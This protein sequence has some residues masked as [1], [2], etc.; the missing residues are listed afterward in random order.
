[1]RGLANRLVRAPAWKLWVAP[2]ASIGFSALWLA[3]SVRRG[4]IGWSIV[5][6]VLLAASIGTVSA[7]I[8]LER[9]LRRALPGP[10]STALIAA[11]SVL[12]LGLALTFYPIVKAFTLGQIQIWLN[13]MLALSAKYHHWTSPNCRNGVTAADDITSAISR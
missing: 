3:M 8:L 2:I 13:G 10:S 4:E 9:G 11:R 6:G 7:A 12:V 5:F 1:M